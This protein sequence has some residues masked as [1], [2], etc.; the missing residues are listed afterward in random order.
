VS[1]YGGQGWQ[2]PY[3]QGQQGWSANPYG[4][5]PYGDPGY[6]GAASY[7]VPSYGEQGWQDPYAVPGPGYGP[8]IPPASQGSA[9]GALVCNIVATFFCCFLLAVPGIIT[10]AI[11][12]GRIQTDP[13]SARNLTK[14][15]WGLFIVQAV[16]GLILGVIYFVLILSGALADP[17]PGY[18]GGYD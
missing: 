8:P 6:G 1:G 15:G 3:Q 7:G 17:D 12:L 11:A 14:W 13:E 9:I 18:G 16:L 2:D 4:G 10:S 5:S